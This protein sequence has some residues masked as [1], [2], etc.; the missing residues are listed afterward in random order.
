MAIII[1]I[2]QNNTNNNSFVMNHYTSRKKTITIYNEQNI[3]FFCP[4]E[5]DSLNII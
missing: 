3:I 4:L 1:I 5:Y 2:V